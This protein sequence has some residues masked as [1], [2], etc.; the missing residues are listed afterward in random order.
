MDEHSS[1]HLFLVAF[2]NGSDI[3]RVPIIFFLFKN[4]KQGHRNAYILLFASLV[5]LWFSAFYV[6]DKIVSMVYKTQFSNLPL[7]M[8]GAYHQKSSKIND[9]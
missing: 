1:S 7:D 8:S 6:A 3:A 4:Q 9:G 5:Q 2:Y